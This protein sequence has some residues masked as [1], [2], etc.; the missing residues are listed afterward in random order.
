VLARLSTRDVRNLAPL[1]LELS[2]AG[3]A[4]VGD[5]G[6]G[7]T[8]LLEAIAYLNLLRSMRGSRDGDVIGFG[9][10]ACLV[11]GQTGG[12]AA[13]TITVAIDRASRSKR[14]TVDGVESRRLADALGTV[15][16][17][18]VSPSDV[19]LIAGGPGERR[20]YLDVL[21]AL[22]DGH[23]LQAL[24][25]Y[26]GALERRNA[27]LRRGGGAAADEAAVWEPALARYGAVVVVARAA[28]VATWG[29]RVAE[30]C[31][32]LGERQPVAVSYRSALAAVAGGGAAA[33]ETALGEALARRRGHDV[34]RGV[35][36]DGPHRDDLVLTLDGRELRAFGSSGQQRT[37]AIALRMAEAE[38]WRAHLGAPPLFLLDD[39][40]AELDADRSRRILASLES[41]GLGQV[42]LVVPRDED[43]PSAF[44]GLERRR[45]RQGVLT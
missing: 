30:R 16:S 9:A 41:A 17:V 37:A 15:P 3:V 39:P 2:P 42:V 28:W 27:A 40:F 26:R 6:H 34:V 24:T 20:R 14:V 35:T 4:V 25:R 31:A 45:M 19:A 29:D 43:I 12:P 36:H 18:L 7:K 32:A 8:N 44:T 33:V 5:N 11:R 21:L 1:D 23:Y 22:T 10:E 38:T 13:R